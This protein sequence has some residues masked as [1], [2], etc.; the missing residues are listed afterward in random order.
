MSRLHS[1]QA[2]IGEIA[3]HFGVEPVPDVE[4][5][6]EIVEGLHGLVVMVKGGRRLLKSMTW[7]FPRHTR[8]GQLR[9]D[10]PHRL[11]LVA[12]LTSPMWDRQVIE[13][14]YRCLIVLTHFGNP[15][16]EAG[17]KTRTWF[18]VKGQ[19]IMAWAGFC[20]NTPEF[21]P[22]YAGM[23]MEANAAIPP[24][25]D[26]MP[27]LLDRH[28]HDLWLEGSIRDVILFQGRE[29]FA[30]DR[31]IVERTEDRWRS[32]AAPAKPAPQM[33]LL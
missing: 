25:N 22:V 2:S 31:M 5:P 28:E 4:V 1:I 7:G 12:N 11:G 8:E 20:R 24:T 32:G 30:A 15:D 18:S 29:P 17:S 3:H 33:A 16:G 23:T 19:P 9:G 13:P 14:R 26:R 10:S 6:G 21:G 27:V